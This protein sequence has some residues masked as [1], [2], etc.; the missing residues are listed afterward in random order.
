MASDDD[1]KPPGPGKRQKRA[2]TDPSQRTVTIPPKSEDAPPIEPEP[3][4][5]LATPP[6]EPLPALPTDEPA[7]GEAGTWRVSAAGIPSPVPALPAVKIDPSTAGSGS[8]DVQVSAANL[9]KA[10][11][12]A[13]SAEIEAQKVGESGKY[14]AAQ[15]TE[16]VVKEA[17]RKRGS[18]GAPPGASGSIDVSLSGSGVP[19]AVGA[20]D[21]QSNALESQPVS[22]SGA[23]AA[24]AP[25][26]GSGPVRGQRAKRITASIQGALSGGVEKLGAGIGA[27]G[28]G[29]SKLGDLTN[30]VPVVGASVG[31]LGE[32]IA[33]AGESI[34][35][36]PRVAQT[37][38]GRLLVRSVVVGFLIVFT[39][40]VV[41]VGFQL[42]AH[43]TPDFRPAAERILIEMGK[44]QAS[45]AQ[46]YE[47]ASPRFHELVKKER[48]LD[49]MADLYATNGK[50]REISAINETLVTTGPTGRVGRVG[51]TASFEKGISRGSISFHWDK[52]EWKLL[53]LGIEVPDNVEI[54]QIERQK[55]VAACINDKGEDV[56]DL[57]NK[58][59]VRDAAETI[60]E[61]IR[62]NRAGEVWDNANDV[63]KQ[64]ESRLRFIQI[65]EE[66]RQALGN[67][68]RILN[69][70]DARAIA[71]LTSAF[72]IVCE[73][74]R[75]SG[76]RVQMDFTRSSKYERWKL[77]RFKVT[78][79]MPRPS[80]EPV[81]PSAV[82]APAAPAV[83]AGVP[84]P[85]PR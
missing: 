62:D 49:D 70:T 13:A 46:V 14:T 52:G 22:A 15:A 2:R 48:F 73:Y 43:D 42:R 4:P 83:D 33:K 23:V 36:L 64:Q 3:T 53:G 5:T 31:R 81:D 21:C 19:L 8:I 11:D 69:V 37:R 56:S 84:S 47:H 39:W 26:E 17:A 25:N 16:L 51:L 68:K 38:R 44:G 58:C 9:P 77:A 28:E 78:V 76:V 66:Q 24:V 27:V 79:P 57:R 40:I 6:T 72:D 54:S 32:G 61:M 12:A 75:S 63:F 71:G 35:A 55:R 85:P 7:A 67:W 18:T 10:V 34:H 41:I 30:K 65:Q 60:L 82:P 20:S 29:V 50:F 45:I 74:E 59:D 1:P 80:E